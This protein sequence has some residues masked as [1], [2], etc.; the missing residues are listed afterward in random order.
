MMA[1]P[2]ASHRN[3]GELPWLAIEQDLSAILAGEERRRR[4]LSSASILQR[5]FTDERVNLSGVEIK[6][7]P[8]RP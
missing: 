8:S 5:R 4:V 1:M 2:A 6:R 3:T 7:T